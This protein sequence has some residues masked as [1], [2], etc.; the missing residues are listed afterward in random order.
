[1]TTEKT[2]PPLWQM[3]F[4]T[5]LSLTGNVTRA[6]AAADI[7][8]KTAYEA[9]ARDDEFAAL[10]DDAIEQATDMLEAEARRRAHDGL[11]RYKFH[12]GTAVLDPRTGE[13]YY[14]LE[15]SDTLLIFLLKGHRPDKY[16]ERYEFS[17]TTPVKQRVVEEVADASDGDGARPSDQGAAGVPPG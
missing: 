6:A 14:E 9:R 13:P 4:L 2:Q 1:M 7:A 10:W 8:R 3:A 5:A 17:E 11:V 15:Y 12:N 16:R